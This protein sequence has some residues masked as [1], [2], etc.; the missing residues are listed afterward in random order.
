MTKAH[1]L[2][3][4]VLLAGCL[5]SNPQ[6]SPGGTGNEGGPGADT[7]GAMDTVAADLVGG[8]LAPPM[9]SVIAPDAGCTPAC[10]GIQCGDDGCGGSCG[11]CADSETCAEGHCVPASCDACNWLQ[12]APT[13]QVTTSCAADA[14]CA[15]GGGGWGRYCD[16]DGHCK[17]RFLGCQ[18]DDECR[19]WCELSAQDA[20]DCDDAAFTCHQ[21]EGCAAPLSWCARADHCQVDED[22]PA[23]NFA[24]AQHCVGGLCEAE[25]RNCGDAADCM[26][27]CAG[28]ENEALCEDQGMECVP[29]DCQPWRSFCA[30]KPSLAA[31]VTEADC[32][33]DN[34]FHDHSC[35]DG[36]CNAAARVCESD[37]QCE[38]WCLEAWPESPDVC[39][40]T[41]THCGIPW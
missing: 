38:A 8:D 10:E 14:D 40:M 26:A 34:Q 15:L 12:P 27:Y 9:D 20:G 17:A 30:L 39:D 23:P 6:P 21:V 33:A 28:T 4:V 1:W 2:G 7:V 5:E 24:V 11:L 18:D 19:A 29:V 41:P 13:C 16:A 22:C 25:L 35:V 36:H 37:G 32:P 31:C 3:L